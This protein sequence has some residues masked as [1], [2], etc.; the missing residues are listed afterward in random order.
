MICHTC[1]HHHDQFI[2]YTYTIVHQ[3]N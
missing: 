2:I 1:V 3:W